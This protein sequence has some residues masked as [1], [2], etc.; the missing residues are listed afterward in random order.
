[1]CKINTPVTYKDKAE[2][3]FCKYC[4]K[5]TLHADFGAGVF[6]TVHQLPH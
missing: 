4:D 2:I 6:C 3:M 1:M 5:Y